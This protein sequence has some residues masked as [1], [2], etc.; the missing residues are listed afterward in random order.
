MDE[1]KF[2]EK[3]LFNSLEKN[4]K[5]PFHMPGHKR[6]G[7]FFPALAKLG[8]ECDITE[9]DGFDNLHNAEGILKNSM[10]LASKLWGSMQ[11]FY[12]VNGST[13][14]I[15]SAI[16][17]CVPFGGR[18]ICA[19]NCHKSVYNA[20]KIRGAK[21][22]FINPKYDA[23]TGVCGEISSEDVK[24][25]CENFGGASLVI[26]TSPTYEGVISDIGAICET[27]HKF[28]IPVLVDEAHGAHL[29]FGSFEK[30]AV[31][32]GADI[33]VQ[34][35]HKTLAS[36]TQTAILHVCSPRVDAK[37]LCENLAIFQTSSPS[38]IF[39]ASMDLLVRT[40]CEEKDAIFRAWQKRLDG[41]YKK[42]KALKNLQILDEKYNLGF[43]FDKS[44]IVILTHKTN[45]SGSELMKIL[46]DKY[47]IECEM[48]S[49][50]YV[51]A[52]TGM[53]DND[54][55][56]QKL[57]DAL[58]EIDKTLKPYNNSELLIYPQEF[59][60]VMTMFDTEK[61]DNCETSFKNA[62]NEICAEYIFAYPPGI[63]III[64]GEKVSKEIIKIV[65]IYNRNGIELLGTKGGNG[66]KIHIIC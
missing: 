58:L 25:A 22:K 64:P 57:S 65:E 5:I 35:L 19:R 61:Y 50:K 66:E 47:N 17:S 44:K 39:M 3:S 26:I 16:F 56:M 30:S 52:M 18:V 20:L 62:E 13:C 38:Y 28:N 21:A 43:A 4:G 32:C 7:A 14:G 9:I 36:L 60:S 51:S 59:E 55:N 63:P 29:S 42:T 12:L 23:K 33:V 49:V 48:C 11:S 27:A 41:F 40:L 8:A 2:A 53:G 37:K 6:N 15:I 54:E 10:C 24:K 46:R 31:H 34:S 1:K 45:I